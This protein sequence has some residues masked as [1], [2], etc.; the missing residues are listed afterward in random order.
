MNDKPAR[1]LDAADLR[2]FSGTE[3]YYRW[4]ILFPR[5]VLTDGTKYLADVG[6]CYWLM[7]A[8]ASHQRKCLRFPE[9]RENQFWT[10]KV[11]LKEREAVLTCQID[12]NMKPTIRQRIPFT[13]FPLEEM[14][15]WV[16]PLG[17]DKYVILL[18]SEH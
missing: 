14:K 7:D 1:K 4:S 2:Q 8:I 10:L 9:L 6:Q 18:P 3:N 12:S 11:N 5:M 15:L 13:D 16:E 17:D